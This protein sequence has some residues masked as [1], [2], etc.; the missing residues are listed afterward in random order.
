[1]T[2]EVSSTVIL[3]KTIVNR[4]SSSKGGIFCASYR[5]LLLSKVVQHL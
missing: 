2:Q 4:K 3:L 1:M 5:D